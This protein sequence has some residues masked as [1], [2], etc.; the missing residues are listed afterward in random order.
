VFFLLFA[1]A[2][3][4][5]ALTAAHAQTVFA[6]VWDDL[7]ARPSGPAGFRFYLQPAMA[8]IA[9]L[10]DGLKDARTGRSPYFWTVLH[11]PAERKARLIEGAKSTSRIILLGVVMD[12]IYQFI[13]LK[14]F[15]LVEM[16]LI[17]LL[18]AFVPYLLL[19]GP[20]C[21]VARYWISRHETTHRAA[22]G[23]PDE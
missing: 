12:A 16:I 5:D 6:R 21:R 22:M 14:S 19:R 4:F 1:V 8:T 7:V 18:L 17:V 3:L 9:A 2:L 20:I 23:S 10:K 11:I 13:E 15:Y